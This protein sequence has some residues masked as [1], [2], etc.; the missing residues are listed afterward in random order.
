MTEVIDGR[1]EDPLLAGFNLGVCSA[2][3][4]GVI[5]PL[6]TIIPDDAVASSEFEDAA[7]GND[8]S[9]IVSSGYSLTMSPPLLENWFLE[10]CGVGWDWRCKFIRV[11]GVAASRDIASDLESCAP[12]HGDFADRGSAGG[13]INGSDKGSGET[14][15][16]PELSVLPVWRHPSICFTDGRLELLSWF[17]KKP[18]ST[19]GPDVLGFRRLRGR[20]DGD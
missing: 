7:S 17:A 11:A 20:T 5:S 14:E 1:S 15:S 13:G 19:D 8:I 4:L 12:M 3:I 16:C 2:T 10:F 18:L 6:V 9:S